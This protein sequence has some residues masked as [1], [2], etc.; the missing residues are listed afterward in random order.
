MTVNKNI[1]NAAD[2]HFLFNGVEL[3]K[4]SFDG[5]FVIGRKIT[6]EPG[7]ESALNVT[8]WEI[9]ADGTS[10]NYQGA[11]LELDMPQCK[12]LA[13]K[14]LYDATGISIIPAANNAQNVYD[15]NGRM[16]RSG[17]TSLEGLPCGIYIVGGRKVVK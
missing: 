17:S 10:T 3:T 9:V 7:E 13:I 16:V 12:T 8:G 1:E 14:A 6:L 5:Q 4:G 11:K 15:L 2:G